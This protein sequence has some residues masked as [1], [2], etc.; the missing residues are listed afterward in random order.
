VRDTLP[1]ILPESEIRIPQS[2]HGQ[3]MS[4]PLMTMAVAALG[5]VGEGSM[6]REAMLARIETLES[7][8][9]PR[10]VMKPS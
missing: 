3:R 8:P 10:P 7:A 6:P 5:M 2:A 1:L 9:T 4:V